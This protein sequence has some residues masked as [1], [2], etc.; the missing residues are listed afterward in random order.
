MNENKSSRLHAIIEGHVQGVGFRMF[1]QTT[2][3]SLGLTGWVRNLWDGNVEVTAEGGQ[4]ILDKLLVA[5]R[6]GPRGAYV[7]NVKSEWS[8]ATNEFERFQVRST[9]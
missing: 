5:L 8:E 6:Q 3:V 2:A 7:I 1:V 9:V 4:A